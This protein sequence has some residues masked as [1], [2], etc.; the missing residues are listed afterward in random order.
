MRARPTPETDGVFMAIAVGDFVDHHKDALRMARDHCE[1]L[2]RERDEAEEKL[3]A[4]ETSITE[5]IHPN[6]AEVLGSLPAALAPGSPLPAPCA[7][8][9]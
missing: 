8:T 4:L 7:Q 1:K 6:I 9:P 3:A 2:E 5:M